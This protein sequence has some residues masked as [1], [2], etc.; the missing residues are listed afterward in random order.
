MD[1]SE[2]IVVIIA[3]SI[4]ILGGTLGY[5]IYKNPDIIL[6]NYAAE[7]SSAPAPADE[8]PPEKPDSSKPANQAEVN[9]SNDGFT[10]KTVTVQRGESVSFINNRE[11]RPMWVASDD[12]PT[13]EKLPKF[14]AGKALGRFP[15]PGEDWSFTFKKPGT[16]TYHDHADP[17]KTGTI[18]VE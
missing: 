5:V 6:R 10:P 13:H 8:S 9:Y 14:D 16:W 15:K 1:K 3:I 18:I 12:H 2:K 11:Q 17:S 7:N 4:A